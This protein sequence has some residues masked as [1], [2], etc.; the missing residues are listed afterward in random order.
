V[1]GGV[2]LVGGIEV[3]EEAFVAAGSVVEA[4][5]PARTVVHGIAGAPG[6]LRSARTTCS[7]AGAEEPGTG[8]KY[9]FCHG[10]GAG[11]AP[12]GA[13]VYPDPL[14]LEQAVGEDPDGK[15]AWILLETYRW[16]VLHGEAPYDKVWD[17]RE[18]YPST[19]DVVAAFG[20]WE[21]LWE[22]AGL[23][24]SYHLRALRRRRR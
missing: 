18:G 3:G 9:G 6:A 19:R 8:S 21:N 4:A 22:L 20:S 17:N 16:T 24:D 1:G 13:F 12:R 23:Y 2:V 7:S 10:P 15:A 5:V 11:A 14:D